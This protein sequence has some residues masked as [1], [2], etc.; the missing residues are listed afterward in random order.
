VH[1][2]RPTTIPDKTA[3]KH[4]NISASQLDVDQ[5]QW[6]SPGISDGPIG[7]QKCILVTAVSTNLVSTRT[8]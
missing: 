5:V 4:R 7:V 2:D 3:P 6:G 1:S 8:C